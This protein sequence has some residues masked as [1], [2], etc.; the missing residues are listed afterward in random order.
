MDF[1]F[2]IQNCREYLGH[3]DIGLP[4][5]LLDLADDVARHLVNLGRVLE[6]AGVDVAVRVGKVLKVW[7]DAQVALITNDP[8]PPPRVPADYAPR[9]GAGADATAAKKRRTSA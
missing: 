8:D 9:V 4:P 5:P 7:R 1:G 6:G 3:V 2:F